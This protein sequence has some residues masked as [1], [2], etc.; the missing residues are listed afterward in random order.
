MIIKNSINGR[1]LSWIQSNVEL[2]AITIVQPVMVLVVLV[3][4]PEFYILNSHKDWREP[5]T[6]TYRVWEG[7]L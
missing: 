6:S 3:W 4:C 2:R 1:K 5:T 7:L